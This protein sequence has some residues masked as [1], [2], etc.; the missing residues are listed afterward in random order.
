[1]PMSLNEATLAGNLGRDPEVRTL[2]GGGQV[3]INLSL[4]TNKV[5]YDRST[6]ER[7][8]QTEWH[9]V[10]VFSEQGKGLHSLIEK[11]AK[12]GTSV[13]VR[14]EIRT[15]K[16]QNQQGQDVYTTEIIVAG[17]QAIFKL[18]DSG[19]SQQRG[20]PAPNGGDRA[21]QQPQSQP[22]APPVPDDDLD[23]AIPF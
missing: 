14:G 11:Y 1:M 18:N 13:F 22:S 9:R 21:R 4:A 16:W 10:V 23:D 2:Q 8:E 19:D 17:P 5:Y 12:K 15:R 3:A 7:K 6:N 20:S